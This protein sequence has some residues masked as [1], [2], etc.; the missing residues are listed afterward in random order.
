VAANPLGKNSGLRVRAPRDFISGLTLVALAA[1]AVWG[2]LDMD[3]GTLHYMG[4]AM[5]PRWVAVL[6]GICGAVLIALSFVRDGQQPEHI[7]L[8]GPVL[9]GAAIVLFGLTIRTFGL[10][11]AGP[12]SLMLASYATPEARL[13]SSI[14]LALAI[15]GFCVLLFRYLL[16]LSM[17][18]LIIPGTSIKI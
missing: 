15:T 18:I 4:P 17:P 12:I 10:A 5:F 9:L 16:D 3:Q 13:R 2:T 6:V 1:V 7:A 11:V 14:V 8:R